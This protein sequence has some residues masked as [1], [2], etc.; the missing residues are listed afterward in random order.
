MI[1]SEI[2]SKII[3]SNLLAASPSQLAAA[4]KYSGRS[5]I[6]R[7]RNV[8][9]GEE[10]TEEFCIRLRDLTGLSEDD[11]TLFGRLLDSTV[12]FT[13]LMNSEFGEVSET[14]KLSIA[15]AFLIDDYSLF[16]AGFKDLKLNRWLLMKGHE[17]EFFFLMLSLFL[18]SGKTKDFYNKHLDSISRYKLILDPL[19]NELKMAFPTHFI[20]ENLTSHIFETPLAKLA[21]PCFLTAIRLGGAILQGYVSNYSEASMY[22]AM[23]KIDGLPD[24]TFWDE[25][26]NK[27]EV[28]FLKFV[29][30]NDK[31]NGLYEYFTLLI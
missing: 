5:T 17:K 6:N 25:S 10:A 21:Y 18:L 20:G 11:L 8:S 9:A 29:P 14:K 28:T 15:K 4:L 16:S 12:D 2:I 1:N 26:E 30:V 7:L 13:H 19:R 24:R 27:N 31:G 23:I 3:E 22:D